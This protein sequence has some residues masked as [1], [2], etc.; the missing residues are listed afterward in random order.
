M[1][2]LLFFLSLLCVFGC[3]DEPIVLP[4]EIAEEHFNN[5]G[6]VLADVG[7]EGFMGESVF[8]KNGDGSFNIYISRFSFDQCYTRDLIM[9][10]S[11]ELLLNDS[12]YLDTSLEAEYE[13]RDGRESIIGNKKLATGEN[14]FYLTELNMDTTELRGDFHLN[15]DDQDSHPSAPTGKVVFE[16]GQFFSEKRE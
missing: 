3:K 12:V 15:F 10:P 7:D 1:L 4:C 8:Q 16:N 2:L 6:T 5:G 11:V 14:W 9:I 13:M